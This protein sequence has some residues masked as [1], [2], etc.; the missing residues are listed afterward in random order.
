MLLDIDIQFKII[1]LA[2]FSGVIV[3]FLFDVYR[4]FRGV[5]KNKIVL[6]IEDLLFWIWCSLVIFLFLL[7]YN[8]A[9]MGLYFYAFMGISLIIYLKTL[10]KYFRSIQHK[11]IAILL[12]NIRIIF[13]NVRYAFKNTLSN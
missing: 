1:I 3:G 10:S 9:L 2:I 4:E 11:I 6:I 5:C 8:Y 13:K 12:K 7:R